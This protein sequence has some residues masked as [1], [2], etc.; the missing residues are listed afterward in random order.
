MKKVI[1]I[2]GLRKQKLSYYTVKERVHTGQ[3]HMLD[4]SDATAI[5]SSFL[6]LFNI[7]SHTRALSI[8]TMVSLNKYNQLIQYHMVG[9]LDKEFI[10]INTSY[11][12]S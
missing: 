10:H 8:M 2:S 7:T 11:I 3:K 12:M 4:S 5:D 1:Y 9:K 6:L